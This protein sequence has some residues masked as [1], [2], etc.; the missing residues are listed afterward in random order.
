[1]PPFQRLLEFPE[2][3]QQ[4]TEIAAELF[5]LTLPRVPPAAAIRRGGETAGLRDPLP[6]VPGGV[7]R[8]RGSA[9]PDIRRFDSLGQ[10]PELRIPRHGSSF[11]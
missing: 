8:G 10:P 7:R 3:G 4:V 2:L 9:G 6:S 1:M 11:T 5:L